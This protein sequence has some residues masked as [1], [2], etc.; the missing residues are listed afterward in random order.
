MEKRS[1]VMKMQGQ[2]QD[3][4]VHYRYACNKLWAET[5]A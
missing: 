4:D 5:L 3:R 2:L 1:A